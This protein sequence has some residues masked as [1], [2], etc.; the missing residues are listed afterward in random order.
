MPTPP[1]ERFARAATVRS[2]GSRRRPTPSSSASRIGDPA[3]TSRRCRCTSRARSVVGAVDPFPA[4]LRLRRHAGRGASCWRTRARRDRLERQQ[5]RQHRLRARPRA[6][7][8]ASSALTGAAVDHLDA[9]DRRGPARGRHPPLRAG[10]PLRR[11][12][13]DRIVATLRA[14]G[15]RRA[16]RRSNAGLADNYSFSQI[17]LD[18]IAAMLR[19]VAESQ[20]AGDRHLLHQLSRCAAGRRGN[21]SASSASRS[22][23]PSRWACGARCARAGVDTRPGRAWGRRVRAMT[24]EPARC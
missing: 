17:P 5:G 6:G 21:G 13:R 14:R 19:D 8:S 2:A 11:R 20:P 15:L 1:R 16:S 10:L 18:E 3:R 23:T 4:D 9:G 12:Y 24:H 7:R 22:T